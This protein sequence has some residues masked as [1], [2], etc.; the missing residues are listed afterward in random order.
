MS[1]PERGGNAF[2]VAV[3]GGFALQIAEPHLNGPG[4]DAPII[5]HDANAGRQQVICGQGPS[6]RAATIGAFEAMGLDLI[7]GTGLLPAVVPGAFDAWCR[8]QMRRY[9]SAPGDG[10]AR[11]ERS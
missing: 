9:G 6:P 7:P 1:I 8:D 2:D 11:L 10:P 5:L 3:A 4:G